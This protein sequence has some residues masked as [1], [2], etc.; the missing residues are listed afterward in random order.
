MLVNIVIGCVLVI[1]TTVVH[2]AAMVAAVRGLKVTHADRWVEVSHLTRVSV[3][4]ALVLIMFLA[5]VVEAGLWAATY[6]VVGAI[7]GLEKA[8][9]FSTVTYTT[10]GYGDVV[11]EENWRLLS[12]LEAANGIIMFGWTTALIVAVVQRLAS[13]LKEEENT[14][15]QQS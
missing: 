6:L 2:A 3:V 7:S 10:L 8:L 1:L 12:S 9:Y 15:R 13:S 5:S 4:A 11:M 14:S